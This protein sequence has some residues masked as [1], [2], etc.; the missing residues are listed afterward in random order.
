MKRRTPPHAMPKRALTVQVTTRLQLQPQSE[1]RARGCGASAKQ[2]RKRRA[3]ES[4][5]GVV[6]KPQF[7]GTALETTCI[8]IV[9]KRAYCLPDCGAVLTSPLYRTPYTRPCVLSCTALVSCTSNLV[10][11]YG[12]LQRHAYSLLD[13]KEV[14]GY[15]LV[16]IR[17]PWGHGEWTG[18]WS[19][20]VL[21]HPAVAP[22][23]F[24]PS[25]ASPLR[26]QV[27]LC[28]RWQSEELERYRS[29]VLRAF[30]APP[31]K[32]TRVQVGRSPRE[33]LLLYPLALV[34][35]GAGWWCGGCI[36]SVNYR[37]CIPPHLLPVPCTRRPRW[38]RMA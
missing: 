34:V 1:S 2:M 32:G 6:Q 4:L 21:P 30:S 5:A 35:G 13:F 27:R 25:H 36:A 10:G 19:D 14:A 8:V 22:Q 37:H 18:P 23:P 11:R 38:S 15:R 12:I 28:C 20:K 3:S 33:C 16:R 31:Q 17:N 29:E 24:A 7:E 9:T 26:G